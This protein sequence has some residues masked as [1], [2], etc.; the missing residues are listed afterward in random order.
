[1]KLPES[2]RKAGAFI[3]G[4]GLLVEGGQGLGFSGLGLSGFRRLVQ[5]FGR[6]PAFGFPGLRLRS[7]FV[8]GL[9]PDP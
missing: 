5:G 1:M 7:C 9:K 8:K 3:Y 6:V 4:L 2:V